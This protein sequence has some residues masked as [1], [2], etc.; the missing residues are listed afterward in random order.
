MA[1]SQ[2]R[3]LTVRQF[4]EE[5]EWLTENRDR[6]AGLWVAIQGRQLLAVAPTAREVFLKVANAKVPPLVILVD[7]DDPPFA[8]W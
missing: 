1:R 2:E 3:A 8:G 5:T 7:K 6:F 4:Q